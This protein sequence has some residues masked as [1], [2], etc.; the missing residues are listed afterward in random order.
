[1]VSAFRIANDLSIIHPIT[2]DFDD[3]DDDISDRSLKR[4]TQLTVNEKRADISCD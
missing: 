2:F 4:I 3:D 1:M